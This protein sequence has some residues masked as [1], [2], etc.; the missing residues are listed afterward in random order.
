MW[1]HYISQDNAVI[2]LTIQATS[3]Y[4]TS[5]AIQ[6][7]HENDQTGSRTLTV[8]TKVDLRPENQPIQVPKS[9]LG[10]VCVRNRTN[11]EQES[12]LTIE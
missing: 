8:I 11:E 4:D 1:H 5:E 6:I 12:G 9:G 7:A 10:F 3:D 2:L